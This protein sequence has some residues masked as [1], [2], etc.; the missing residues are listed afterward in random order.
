MERAVERVEHDVG[1]ETLAE[2]ATGNPAEHDLA[3]D[4]P[5]SDKP[6]IGQGLA[7][8]FID[9]SSPDQWSQNLAVMAAEGSGHKAH[10]NLEAF[11]RCR[12]LLHGRSPGHFVE[13]GI[14]DDR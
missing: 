14:N 7:Q 5:A 8:C 4:F 6:A 9:L 1:I 13:H 3:G 10:G 11:A 12:T 2:F